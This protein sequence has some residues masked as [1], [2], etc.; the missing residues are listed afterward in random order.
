MLVQHRQ[1]LTFLDT[2]RA[3]TMAVH[4]LLKDR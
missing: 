4:K 3:T 1:K 2:V